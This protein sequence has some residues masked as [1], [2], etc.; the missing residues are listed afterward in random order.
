LSALNILEKSKEP[1]TPFTDDYSVNMRNFDEKLDRAGAC[2][3]S[4][5]IY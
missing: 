3:E 4:C 5:E 1:F 2:S